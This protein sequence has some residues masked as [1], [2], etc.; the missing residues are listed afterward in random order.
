[1]IKLTPFLVA[2]TLIVLLSGCASETAPVVPNVPVAAPVPSD[3]AKVLVALDYYEPMYKLDTDGRVTHLRLTNRHVPAPVLGE[4]NKL[5][6]LQGLD[7]FA[8][9]VTDEGLAQLKDLQKLRS[10][11]L[12]A[13]AIS[14]V[15]LVHLEQLKSLQWVWLP[16]NKVTEGAIAKLKEARPEMNI[17]TH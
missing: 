11:G 17:Y 3:D 1:M 12:G 8:A 6:H 2:S 14:D 10:I 4:V 7:L 16:K 15:G 5:A 13:T 9:T